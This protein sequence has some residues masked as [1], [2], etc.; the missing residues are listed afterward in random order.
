MHV[1]LAVGEGRVSSDPTYEQSE[2]QYA[3]VPK[4]TILMCEHQT[5]QHPIL[6]RGDA[7]AIP[8]AAVLMRI[9]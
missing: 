4:A 2:Q 7:C 6:S 9:V 3:P 5:F 1:N 8:N